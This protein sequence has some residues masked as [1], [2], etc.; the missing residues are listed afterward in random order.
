MEEELDKLF[1]K[2]TDS[3]KK[4]KPDFDKEIGKI[5]TGSRSKFKKFFSFDNKTSYSRNLEVIA[6]YEKYDGVFVLLSSQEDITPDTVVT[7][8]KNLQEVETLF[9]D[10]KNFVDI[11]PIRHRLEERVRGHVLI[12]ILALLLKRIFEIDCLKSK[13]IMEALEEIDKVKLVR[14]K[15]KFSVKE[16]RYQIIPKVTNLNQEQKNYFKTVGIKN[17][18]NIEK[19]MW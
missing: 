8:Y 12:C 9:D 6:R 10:F 14:F 18:M 19:F 4:N 3:K 16:E 17:P 13:S 11:R 5:F 1:S 2:L 7:S 15:V